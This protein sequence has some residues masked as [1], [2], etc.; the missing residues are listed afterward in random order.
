VQVRSATVGDVT[1]MFGPLVNGG[2]V[3]TGDTFTGKVRLGSNAA[4]P[5]AAGDQ[6]LNNAFTN[7]SATTLLRIDRANAP[8]VQGNPFTDLA[9][10]A[11]AVQV[12]DSVAAVVSGNTMTLAGAASTGILVRNP[13]SAAGVTVADNR[14]DTAGHGTG[15]AVTKTAGTSLVANVA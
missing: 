2:N 6:V 8:L 4:N 3:F 1:Q 13:D 15:I 7:G 12:D 14:I 5:L 10:G 9:S 11:T